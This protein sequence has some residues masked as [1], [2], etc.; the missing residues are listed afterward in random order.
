MLAVVSFLLLLP[1]RLLDDYPHIRGDVM[2][3]Y[4]AVLVRRYSGREWTLEGEDYEGLT[5]L[6]GGEKPSKES[7]DSAWDEVRAEIAAEK[8]AKLAA[9]ESAKAKLAALGLTEDEV[10]A[11]IG[12]V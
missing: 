2:T 3:D 10:N 6:D 9:K 1:W 4:A 8:E 7:L 12:G 5:M 11:L